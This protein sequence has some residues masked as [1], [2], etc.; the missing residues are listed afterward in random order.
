MTKKETIKAYNTRQRNLAMYGNKRESHKKWRRIANELS[1]R[2]ITLADISDES[3]PKQYALM[4]IAHAEDLSLGE[5]VVLRQYA[6]AIYDGNV[7]SAEFLRDTLGEKPSTDMNVNS[8]GNG[9][10]EMSVADLKLLLEELKK[11]RGESTSSD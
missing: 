9:L 8:T 2:H 1:D 11:E 7:K 5:L 4:D 6:N 3:S 10:D